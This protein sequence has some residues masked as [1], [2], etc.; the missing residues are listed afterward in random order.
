MTGV[1]DL[2]VGAR[3]LL[4]D[5][6]RWTQGAT[7]RDQNGHPV[8]PREEEAVQWCARGAFL[9]MEARLKVPK[10]SCRRAL[11]LLEES[12]FSTEGTGIVAIND[13]LGYD[14][15]L[16]MYDEAIRMATTEFPEGEMP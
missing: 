15:V 2:L 16:A 11:A 12:A 1:I 8:L 3:E 6:S 4:A 14:K 5:P 10:L 9:C 7:A 13:K